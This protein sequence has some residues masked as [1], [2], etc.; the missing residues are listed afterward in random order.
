LLLVRQWIS[1]IRVMTL[2]RMGRIGLPSCP[3]DEIF[4]ARRKWD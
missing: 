4:A 3:A 2:Y 1:F